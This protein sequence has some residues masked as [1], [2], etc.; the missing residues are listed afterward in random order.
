MRGALICDGVSDAGLSIVIERSARA[1]GVE[2][3]VDV[4]NFDQLRPGLSLARRLAVLPT[5]VA[6]LDVLFVHRDAEGGDTEHRHMEI[7]RAIGGASLEYPHVP[8]VPVRMTEAWLLCDPAPIRRVVGNPNGRTPLS[9]P[10][11]PERMIDPKA[12]LR[13]LLA[14]AAEVQ[15]RRLEQL[16][17]RFPQLRR[18]LLETLDVNGPISRLPSFVRFNENLAAWCLI[19]QERM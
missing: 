17:R 9:L 15:G 16:D 2:L 3:V 10:A 4:V 5:L 13:S 12:E 18:Q 11:D 8:V 19:A 1:L 7:K 14:K 6:S